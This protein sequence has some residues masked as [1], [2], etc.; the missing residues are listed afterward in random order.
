MIILKKLSTKNNISLNYLKWMNDPDVQ[1]FTEQRY[2]RHSL[3]DIRD[4]VQSKNTS[5]DEFL[6]G[7]FIKKKFYF[8]LEI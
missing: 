7:I 4:F 8:T 6:F 2:K 5:K 1:K 3:K